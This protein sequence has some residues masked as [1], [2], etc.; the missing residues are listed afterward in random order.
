MNESNAFAGPAHNNIQILTRPCL[1]VCGSEAAECSSRLRLAVCPLIGE[2]ILE[3]S[4]QEFIGPWNAAQSVD[5]LGSY[6]IVTGCTCRPIRR[7]WRRED[8]A[9]R[10]TGDDT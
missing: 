3:D 9:T 4:E 1:C 7:G 8:R 6:R 10:A 2:L 5:R